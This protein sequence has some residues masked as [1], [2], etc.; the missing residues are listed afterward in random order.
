MVHNGSGSSTPPSTAA[1]CPPAARPRKMRT[2]N[3]L[4]S[5]RTPGRTHQPV[6]F[7][8]LREHLVERR[9]RREED[10]R[11]HCAHDPPTKAR[12]QRRSPKARS[13]RL[14]VIEE[15]HPRRCNAKP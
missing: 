4:R 13:A 14:T 15:R 10:D 11:V 7:R 2:I 1:R 5:L 3:T 6:H 12:Q 8:V 9:D